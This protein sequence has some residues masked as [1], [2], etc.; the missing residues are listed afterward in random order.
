MRLSCRG[1]LIRRALLPLILSGV[2]AGHLSA[3][4]TQRDI[5][6]DVWIPSL[7]ASD[8]HDAERLLAVQ[9]RDLVRIAHE[10]SADSPRGFGRQWSHHREGVSRPCADAAGPEPVRPSAAASLAARRSSAPG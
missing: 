8:A 6:R 10:D 5:E 3:Q 7:A 2:L 1:P 9:S 4:A